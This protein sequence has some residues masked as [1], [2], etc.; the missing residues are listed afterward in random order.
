MRDPQ[1]VAY[2]EFKA[3]VAANNVAEVFAHGNTIQGALRKPVAL[4]DK[5]DRT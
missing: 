1:A 3:E 5:K 4:P 2:T